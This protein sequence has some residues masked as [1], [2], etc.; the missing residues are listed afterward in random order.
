M[1]S[2]LDILAEA[3][4]V[5]R[6]ESLLEFVR[7]AN[8]GYQA[9]WVH[10]LI[11]AELQEFSRA[12]A[13]GERPRLMINL[14]PRHGKSPLS[15]IALPCYH[16]GHNPADEVMLVSYSADLA[17]QFSYEARDIMRRDW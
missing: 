9:G 16:V 12:I 5:A 3:N 10:R 4:R 14:P 1:T 17:N 8:T 11:C 6:R 15:S 13:R 2:A 7:D